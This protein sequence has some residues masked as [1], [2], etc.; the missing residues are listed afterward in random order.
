MNRAGLPLGLMSVAISTLM[1]AAAWTDVRS[2]RI[3][4]ALT[5]SG[6]GVAIALRLLAGPAAGID[7]VTGAILAFVLCLPFFVLGVL[8]GGDAKLLMALGAFTGPRDLLVAML[9]IASIGGIIGAVDAARRGILLPVLYNCGNIIKHWLTL[10]RRGS[11]R[12]LA[13]SGA[14]AIPYGVAIAVGSLVWWFAEVTRL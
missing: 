10:G 3:P 1:L 11:N 6:F 12:S 14:L 8:G 2:R 7:G 5:V 4:N 9:I 13:T